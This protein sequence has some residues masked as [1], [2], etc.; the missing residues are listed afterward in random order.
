V[1]NPRKNQRFS[2]VL[3]S[4]CIDGNRFHAQPFEGSKVDLV[5]VEGFRNALIPKIEVYRANT[6]ALLLAWHDPG[7]IPVA[8]DIFIAAL[9]PLID[10]NDA[11]VIA[12]HIVQWMAPEPAMDISRAEQ[13]S[14]AT[15]EFQADVCCSACSA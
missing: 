9:V 13:A 4:C 6:D 10:L 7:V 1:Q 3:F 8:S 2:G 14:K 11:N 12:A 15:T 5:L